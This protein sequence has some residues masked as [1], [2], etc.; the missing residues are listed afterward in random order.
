MQR[1]IIEKSEIEELKKDFGI[2]LEQM[3]EHNFKLAIDSIYLLSK[4]VRQFGIRNE[5]ESNQSFMVEPQ[6]SADCDLK[7]KDEPEK[8]IDLVE[9]KKYYRVRLNQTGYE[10]FNEYEKIYIPELVG[11]SVNLT[12]SDLIFLEKKS[13]L[14]RENDFQYIIHIESSD[15]E[16]T[17][18]DFL[19]FK[20]GIVE[21]EGKNTYVV[22]KNI[23]DEEIPF[24]YVIGN[25]ELDKLGIV[26]G[27]IVDVRYNRKN[28]SQESAKLVWKYPMTNSESDKTQSQKMLD[29]SNDKADD[30]FV[31]TEKGKKIK[32][33]E[34]KKLLLVGMDI[35]EREFSEV[36]KINKVEFEAYKGNNVKRLEQA[37]KRSDVIIIAKSYIGHHTSKP[38]IAF[39]KKYKKK[40]DSFDGFGLNQFTQAIERAISK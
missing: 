16:P 39:A 25:Y 22:R 28:L 8:N 15:N 26:S 30:N 19:T 13:V 2:L 21:L 6:V 38:T 40:H 3:D 4:N 20:M 5:S 32:G 33:L 18:S 11:K 14:K 31:K 10:A 7:D 24:E 1:M 27:D 29:F 35:R 12:T 36:L 23:T 17:E 37:V 34:G 9:E